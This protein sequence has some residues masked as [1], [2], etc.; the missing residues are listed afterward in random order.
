MDIDRLKSDLAESEAGRA[1]DVLHK[2]YPVAPLDHIQRAKQIFFLQQ[3]GFSGKSIQLA[4]RSS[5]HVDLDM[6]DEL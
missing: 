4:M 6:D 3:R 2:K 1:I 5:R